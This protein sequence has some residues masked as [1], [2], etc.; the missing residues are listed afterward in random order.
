MPANKKAP[1]RPGTAAQ[2]TVPAEQPPAVRLVAANAVGVTTGERNGERVARAALAHAPTFLGIVE[3]DD[4]SPWRG[5]HPFD[6]R[7]YG[8]IHKAPGSPFDGCLLAYDRDRAQLMGAPRWVLGVMPFI[9]S[10]RVAMEARYIL[11]ATFRLDAGTPWQRRRTVGVLHIP[12]PRFELLQRPMA[13]KVGRMRLDWWM[14]DLNAHPDQVHGWWPQA[15]VRRQQ[16]L[17]VCGKGAGAQ[18]S[19]ATRLDL[20]GSDH[21]G[22]L[23]TADSALTE[24]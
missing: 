16:V 3:A 18:L 2:K 17:Y 21:P 14:G 5:G 15:S 19:A 13:N 7:R 22:A 24:A 4:I 20:A 6:L 12:P 8:V 1:R 10:R 23:V 11:A 9:D